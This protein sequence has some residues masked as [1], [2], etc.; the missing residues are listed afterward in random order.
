MQSAEGENTKDEEV[1]ALCKV[2]E[3]RAQEGY[4]ASELKEKFPRELMNLFGLDDD[5]D[6]GTA[7]EQLKKMNGGTIVR[8]LSV[9]RDYVATNYRL[10]TEDRYNKETRKKSTSYHSEKLGQDT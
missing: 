2:M 7:A 1:D 9:F 10:T 5:K 6:L 8:K 4:F 3:E